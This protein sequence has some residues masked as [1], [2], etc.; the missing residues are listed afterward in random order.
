MR[1]ESRDDEPGTDAWQVNDQATTRPG[2]ELP[3]NGRRVLLV[4]HVLLAAV[5][6]GGLVAVLAVLSLRHAA[7]PA[8]GDR[9]AFVLL[10]YLV[11]PASLGFIV[12]GAGFS[13][14]TRWGFVRY[15][16]VV[17][18]WL[19]TAALGVALVAGLAPEVA[20]VASWSDAG[21]DPAEAAAYEAALGAARLWVSGCLLCAVSLVA[22]SVFKPGRAR[23]S[24]QGTVS[25][26]IQLAVSLL[27][28]GLIAAFVWQAVALH[29]WR[30]MPVRSL[31]VAGL[32][33]GRHE[34]SATLAGF[35]YRV[36]IDV[37]GGRLLG[38]EILRSRDSGYARRAGRVTLKIVAAQS[39]CV[40]GVTG[41]TTTSRAIQA[42]VGDALARAAPPDAPVILCP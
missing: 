20:L 36:G 21:L 6:A 11:V 35:D 3:P 31:A 38:V 34:G 26:R 18:K 15:P 12:T 17:V 14:F 27:A 1:L 5:T 16:W 9:A 4:V 25:R 32:P 41:A 42:A 10:E 39:S 29:Q 13:L 30:R 28:A 24:V 40:D 19:G 7:M 33:D 22:L 2:L 23:V 37:E 8:A